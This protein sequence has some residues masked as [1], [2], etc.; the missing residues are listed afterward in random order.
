MSYLEDFT[1]QESDF[2]VIKEVLSSLIWSSLFCIEHLG[3]NELLKTVQ[4]DLK[5]EE[6]EVC[7]EGRKKK[8]MMDNAVIDGLQEMKQ[9]IDSLL[10]EID[11]FDTEGCA[12]WVSLLQKKVVKN[13]KM[14]FSFDNGMFLRLSKRKILNHPETVLYK[15]LLYMKPNTDDGTIAISGNINYVST[16]LKY[17]D[18]RLNI[19]MLDEL[20]LD[21]F[22]IEL[23]HL[24]FLFQDNLL[25]RI[26]NESNDFGR[27]W[28][29]RCW[30]INGKVYSLLSKYI[31]LRYKFENVKYNPI[32]D[33]FE[34]FKSLTNPKT[35]D[36]LIDLESYL[37]DPENYN[38]KNMD[39]KT[40]DYVLTSM[41]IDMSPEIIRKYMLFYTTSLFCY[42]TNI[43][44]DTS[45]DETLRNWFGN[46]KWKL[47]Y[48]ASENGYAADSFHKCC[49]DQGPTFTL[50]K[51]SEGWIFGGFTN[52]SWKCEDQFCMFFIYINDE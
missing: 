44:D 36:V 52:Q 5:A 17:M 4:Q 38:V 12:L 6:A 32:L 42:N 33:R 40:I 30:I 21:R 25:D 41:E 20:I 9:K 46:Y 28:K 51:S 2:P 47:L 8:R 43:L 31:K 45:Y 10:T 13:R 39:I 34:L 22:C 16:I 11:V 3:Y 14:I 48:K 24:G 50:I 7:E 29:N 19:L 35:E 1:P 27:R 15:S 49:D 26:L 23:I 18:G 37:N